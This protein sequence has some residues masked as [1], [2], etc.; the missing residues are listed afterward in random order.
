MSFVKLFRTGFLKVHNFLIKFL[1]K[2]FPETNKL[3]QLLHHLSIPVSLNKDVLCYAPSRLN[4]LS[5]SSHRR[6]SVKKGILKNF[7]IFAGKHLCWSIFFD[8]VATLLKKRLQHSFPVNI[9]KFLK[10][11]MV[12]S[13]FPSS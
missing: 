1:D 9:A 13:A 4:V 2:S 10:T 11:T 5:R 7:T 12:A 8:K 6:C 3:M